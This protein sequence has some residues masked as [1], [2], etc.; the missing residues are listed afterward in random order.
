MLLKVPKGIYLG[1]IVFLGYIQTTSALSKCVNI[2]YDKVKNDP[3]ANY[4]RL[5]SIFL[6][7]LLAHFPKY[8][9]NI[10]PINKYKPGQLDKCKASFYVGTYY[11]NKIP[12]QFLEEFEKTDK[13]V[14]WIGYN[15][16]QLGPEK[17]ERIWDAKFIGLTSLDKKNKDSNGHP[18]FYR[19]YNYKGQTWEKSGAYDKNNP[20]VF[21]GAWELLEFASKSTN[22][23]SR[24]NVVSTSTHSTSKKEI[25]YIF[26]NNK[27]K[28]IVSDLPFSYMHEG[29]RYFIFADILF[30]ILGEQPRHSGKKRAL[31]R[32]EDVNARTSIKNLNAISEILNRLNVPF[33]SAFIPV[34]SD[35]L[36]VNGKKTLALKFGDVPE[37]KN[38]VIANTKKNL[39]IINHGTTHQYGRK[40]NP[41]SGESGIDYEYWD[42]VNNKKLNKDTIRFTAKRI[43]RGV[44]AFAE[45]G[46]TPVAFEVPHYLA[47]PR[48]YTVFGQ[49]FSWNVGRVNYMTVKKID[50]KKVDA[51]YKIEKVG[52]DYEGERFSQ[53]KRT[54]VEYLNKPA[55]EGQLFPYELFGDYYGQRLVPESL[56]YPSTLSNT[57]K[58]V[59]EGR[60]LEEMFDDA[61]RNSVLRDY[62]AS[63]FVHPYLMK[64]GA[65]IPKKKIEW[66]VNSLREIGYEFVDL[67]SFVKDDSNIPQ[68]KTA[69]V[70]D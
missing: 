33:A 30:D 9:P 59:A 34:Y 37:I 12:Q 51:A 53:I 4:G 27:N 13:S 16:W 69:I 54:N 50:V 39:S 14:V 19:F 60:T 17:I 38:W 67:R 6:Q 47:S 3:N 26:N 1:L 23:D 28:W 35:P 62:W 5:H 61:K 66:F 65:E 45:V 43:E 25:P 42:M 22:K 36:G 24:F 55:F 49:Y 15:S 10:T 68:V 56:N 41:V 2:Y 29:D 58:K 70:T 63:F 31:F 20:E 8:Q 44:K 52:S 48:N 7:N 57:T 46:V 11:D 32:I 21:Y 18:G 40:K 64:S